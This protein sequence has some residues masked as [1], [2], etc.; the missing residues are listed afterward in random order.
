MFGSV[1]VGPPRSTRTGRVS[2]DAVPPLALSHLCIA[3]PSRDLER[4]KRFWVHGVGMTVPHRAE[5]GADGSHAL[6]P[7][8]PC[9]W[10]VVLTM[11]I[12]SSIAS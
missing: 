11:P 10:L 6:R 3:R 9:T 2:A 1:V 7:A 5:P 12:M 4:T 8:R